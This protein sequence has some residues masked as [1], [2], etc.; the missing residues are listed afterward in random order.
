MGIVFVGLIKGK[1]AVQ[2]LQVRPT[3]HEVSE[4]DGSTGYR[5]IVDKPVWQVKPESVFAYPPTVPIRDDLA[6][7]LLNDPAEQILPTLRNFAER[8]PAGACT[9]GEP[10]SLTMITVSKEGSR[11]AIVKNLVPGR[12]PTWSTLPT[13]RPEKCTPE[14]ERI[15]NGQQ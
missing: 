13:A 7:L 12:C 6:K 14:M 5:W 8:P 2:A 15:A 3:V 4:A 1:L 10:M 11:R 9:I